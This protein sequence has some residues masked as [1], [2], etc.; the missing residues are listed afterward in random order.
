VGDAVFLRFTPSRE[1][2]KHHKGGKL[3][4]RII[5]PLLILERIGAI[6]YRLDLLDE[7]TGIQDVYHVL[8]LKKYNP[9][10]EHMLNEEPL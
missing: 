3:S 6:A 5:G 8:Q 1:S 7:L 10:P 4:P 9:N 2:L